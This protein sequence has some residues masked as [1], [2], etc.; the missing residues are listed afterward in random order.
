MQIVQTKTADL[1]PSAHNA[2]AH[3]QAQVEQIAA[4]IRE[5]GFNVPLLVDG[6]GGLIAG[7]GRLLAAELLGLE[8]VPTIE[9]SHLD[10]TQRRAYMLADNRLAQ[11]STWDEAA[12]AEELRALQVAD[13]DLA[14][15]GF[16]EADLAALIPDQGAGN[17]N[18]TTAPVEPQAPPLPPEPTTLPGDVWQIGPHRIVCGDCTDRV[19]L[20]SLLVGAQPD[21][22]CT[23]PPYCSGGF[24]ETGKAAGS[25]GTNATHKQ[26]ANDRLSTRGYIRLLTA[27]LNAV[28]A[29]FVYAF[30]DWRMWIPL[31]DLVESSGYGVRSMIVWD[32]GTPG[33]GRGWRAQHELVLWGCKSTPPFPEKFGGFGNVLQAPRTGNKNHTTEKPVELMVKLLDGAPFAGT[34]YDPFTGSGSTGVACHQAGRV[35][36]GCELDAAYVDVAVQRLQEATGEAAHLIA[37]GQVF[38]DVHHERTTPDTNG[39]ARDSGQP[40]QTAAA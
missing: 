21:L 13:V 39:A 32:K 22:I 26:I 19:A 8:T 31:F 36:Y 35:F 9:L 16:T 29:G 4:S 17:Q 5:Y 28:P 1:V 23:D 30:T 2:R 14:M 15:V 18:A 25:V 10:E 12:L 27:A 11:G 40:E 37:T 24:Q 3:P 34:V 38:E 7:H 6:A 33:M 20:D